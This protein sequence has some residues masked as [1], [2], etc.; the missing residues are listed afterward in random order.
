[1]QT[2]VLAPIIGK[3]KV[4]RKRTVKPSKRWTV[5]MLIAHIA[6]TLRVF[7]H[8]EL[9]DVDSPV[10]KRCQRAIN[11]RWTCCTP[12]V[13]RFT[14]I[15]RDHSHPERFRVSGKVF[16]YAGMWAWQAHIPCPSWVTISSR[17]F[18]FAI[19]MFRF[20]QFCFNISAAQGVTLR[21]NHNVADHVAGI[22]VA[23]SW[24]RSTRAASLLWL[25]IMA[26]VKML[27]RR[28]A[29]MPHPMPFQKVQPNTSL[30]NDS[31]WK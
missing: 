23:S 21:V 6:S 27:P 2:L 5:G 4:R 8:T 9:T 22:F 17:G 20:P 15:L 16:H 29:L 1:M 30:S 3:W 13:Y 25:R 19:G 7:A 14:H 12:R 24:T 31:F 18:L 28:S 10:A 11:A 26:L